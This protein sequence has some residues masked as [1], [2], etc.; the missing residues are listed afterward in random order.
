MQIA[1]NTVVKFDYTLRNSEGETLD[2]SE[3]REPLA[4]LHGH[5]NIIPGLEKAMTGRDE[6]EEFSVTVAAEDAYGEH[7]AELV[8][9]VPRSSFQGVEQLEPGMQFQAESSAGPMVVTVK[10]VGDEEVTVDG[11]HIL[12]GQELQFEV[13]VKE[14]RSATDEEIEHGHVHE[15]GEHS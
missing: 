1:E 2:T 8:Q 6:G 11:N 7:R 15:G 13:A 12:A 5:G 10:D 9:D 3:G 14:V 4:Y